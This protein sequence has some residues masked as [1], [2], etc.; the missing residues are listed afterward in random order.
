MKPEVSKK[1]KKIDYPQLLLARYV[2]ANYS[3]VRLLTLRRLCP[4]RQSSASDSFVYSIAILSTFNKILT[5]NNFSG[6]ICV[7]SR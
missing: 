2:I 5:R 6:V 3:L 1:K 7:K 4:P